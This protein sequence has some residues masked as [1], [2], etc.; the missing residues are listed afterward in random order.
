M[1]SKS[2]AP[3]SIEFLEE[4]VDMISVQGDGNILFKRSLA[5]A[6]QLTAHVNKINKATTL[7]LTMP[8]DEELMTL[9]PGIGAKAYNTCKSKSQCGGKF[10]LSSNVRSLS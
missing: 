5:T 4:G 7:H 8:L 10:G 1:P 6:A 2:E 3:E 9:S